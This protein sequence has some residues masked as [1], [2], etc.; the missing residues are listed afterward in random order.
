MS[1][2][3]LQILQQ[4]SVIYVFR[5]V[6]S[7]HG[8]IFPES[9]AG[10]EHSPLQHSLPCRFQYGFDG[11]RQLEDCRGLIL[12]VD[13]V[14]NSVFWFWRLGACLGLLLLDTGTKSCTALK[15][16]SEPTQI[17]EVELNLFSLWISAAARSLTHLLWLK[18][19]P[20]S[21]R[22]SLRMGIYWKPVLKPR[23]PRL[24]LFPDL[25][26]GQLLLCCSS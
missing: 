14:Q 26:R 2:A 24:L 22:V 9:C 13:D 7:K 20:H 1:I 15:E 5:A 6:A 10:A 23:Y 8:L 17:R 18:Y 16:S 12:Q 3:R 21:P 4:N 19:E 25:L 11:W